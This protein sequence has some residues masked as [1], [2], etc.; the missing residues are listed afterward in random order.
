MN[1]NIEN[2]VRSAV[3]LGVGLP[4]VLSISNFTGVA[5]RVAEQSLTD[6]TSEVT[7]AVKYELAGPCVRYMLSKNESK[8]EREAKND[9][10]DVV[11]GPVNHTETC[12]W[13]L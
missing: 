9:I 2:L 1:L 11:G 3:V 12:N 4:L 10:E 13:V 7:S 6:P 5:T 8:L